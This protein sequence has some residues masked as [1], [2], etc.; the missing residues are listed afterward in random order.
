MRYTQVEK[1][2]EEGGVP[3]FLLLTLA[4]WGWRRG[5]QAEGGGG[6]RSK[7]SLLLATTAPACLLFA[8]AAA[9]CCILL[10]AAAASGRGVQARALLVPG[11]AAATIRHDGRHDGTAVDIL[12]IQSGHRGWRHPLPT[13]CTCRSRMCWRDLA[14]G[15][16]GDG[17]RELGKA[18]LTENCGI[19]LEPTQCSR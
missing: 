4:G 17:H 1:E 10:H 2:K 6:A 5:A 14:I 19:N 12:D 9:A 7:S 16:D 3:T 13:A 15:G 11:L 18:R 8:A